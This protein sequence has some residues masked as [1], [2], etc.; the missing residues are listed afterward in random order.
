MTQ[1][2]PIAVANPTV[3][4]GTLAKLTGPNTPAKQ[5]QL[6][7]GHKY[8][9]P[10]PRL[11]YLGA[12]RHVSDHLIHGTPLN[13]QAPTLR[14]HERSVVHGMIHGPQLPPGLTY[15]RPSTKGVAWA[16]QG[17]TIS[18]FPDLEVSNGTGAGA[19]KFSMTQDVLAHGV[20]SAMAELLFHHRSQILQLPNVQGGYCLIVEPRTGAL[21]AAGTNAQVSLNRITH[22]C[23]L[24]VALWPSL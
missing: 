18:M 17:V 20:G 13:P 8:K 3:S 4:F 14:S 7:R 19:V 6:L 15:Q 22:A 16:Y 9:Q 12:T 11:S 23:Q 5:M 10:G 1:P 21:Y 2:F 24:I